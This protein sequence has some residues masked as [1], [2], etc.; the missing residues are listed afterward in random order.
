MSS[1]ET[2]EERIASIVKA[3]A[4][5]ESEEHYSDDQKGCAAR[6]AMWQIWK[7]FDPEGENECKTQAF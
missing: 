6:A 4:K 3:W 5:I 1:T 2:K 7:I